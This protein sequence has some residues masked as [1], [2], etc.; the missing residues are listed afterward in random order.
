MIAEIAETL[1][2]EAPWGRTGVCPRGAQV[3]AV[4][5]VSEKPDSS[6]KTSVAPWRFF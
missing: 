5:G 3:F 1:A 2:Q 4:Y 6:Q